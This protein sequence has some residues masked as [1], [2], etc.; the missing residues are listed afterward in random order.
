MGSGAE[1][2]GPTARLTLLYPGDPG[3]S[4]RPGR[5]V[6]QLGAALPLGTRGGPQASWRGVGGGFWS[7]SV[8]R[9]E[10]AQTTEVRERRAAAARVPEAPR[11]DGTGPVGDV[12]HEIHARRQP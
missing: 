8:A 2:T 6:R 12:Q 9:P 7:V 4:V 1:K 5:P 3:R 10:F 11:T